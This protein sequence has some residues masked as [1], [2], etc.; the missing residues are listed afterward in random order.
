MRSLRTRLLVLWLMVATS[1]AATGFVLFEFYRQSA[2]S[3]IMRAEDVVARSCRDIGERYAFVMAGW[4]GST[5]DIDDALKERLVEA[6]QAALARAPG[7]EGGIWQADAGSLAY[8]FPTYEGTGPKTDLPEAERTSIRQVNGDVARSERPLTMR[9]TTRSQVLLLHACPIAGPLPNV[10]GWTM[11]R[12]FTGQGPAYNQLLIGLAVLAVTVLGSAIWLGGILLSWSQKLARLQASLTARTDDLAALPLTGE[13]E[14]DRLVDALNAAG[15]RG[16]EERRR[17]SAAERLAAVGRL[18]AGIAHEIR[19]PIAAMRLKAENAIAS[20]DQGRRTSA[21]QSILLQVGKLD[22]LLRDLLA[23]TQRREPDPA[24]AD[25]GQF[26]REATDPHRE[27]AA[28]KGVSLQAAPVAE[29]PT[30]PRFDID[31]VRRALDNLILNAVQNTP[32]GGVVTVAAAERD[33]KLHFRV[34]DTG[35]GVPAGLRDRLFEPFATA[36]ADG[37]GLG[38]AIA[39]EIARAHGGEARLVSNTSSGAVFEIELPWRPF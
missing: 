10:T 6:A 38:L 8:A 20:D 32:P 24:K 14:L 29:T 17:A 9:Q 21:L 36:R 1:A 37:T 35:P 11:T 18:A 30:A 33:R 19:N 12:V 25:L 27:L 23:M 7:V 15:K 13:R 39:R 2:N 31:Q 28:A 4:N 34:S 22:G 3:Q 16:G 26:L 5:A